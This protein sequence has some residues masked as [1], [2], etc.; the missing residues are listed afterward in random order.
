MHETYSVSAVLLGGEISLPKQEGADQLV[1]FKCCESLRIF[2]AD[3]VAE[4]LQYGHTADCYAFSS[5]DLKAFTAFISGYAHTVTEWQ[6]VRHVR[7]FAQ[8]AHLR[9]CV[10]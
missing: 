9:G 5:F 2:Y 8:L 6:W 7:Q 1:V 3:I 4:Q 10:K